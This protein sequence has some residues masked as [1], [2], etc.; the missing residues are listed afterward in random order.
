MLYIPVSV[1]SPTVNNVSEGCKS[2]VE[3]SKFSLLELYSGPRNSS[4]MNIC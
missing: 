2:T 3:I 4:S 1:T